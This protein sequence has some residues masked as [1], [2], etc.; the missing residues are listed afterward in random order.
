MMCHVSMIE[1]HENVEPPFCQI[2][3]VDDVSA[4]A[5]VLLRATPTTTI[6][7]GAL[8]QVSACAVSARPALGWVATSGCVT[9][10]RVATCGCVT[11]GCVTGG[12]VHSLGMAGAMCRAMTLGMAGALC[13]AMTLRG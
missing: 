7:E 11:S 13:R 9:L 6:I 1:R 2:H 12:E 3:V 10:G 8:R 5:E 4:R